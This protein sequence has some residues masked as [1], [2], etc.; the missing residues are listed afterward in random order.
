MDKLVSVP[1]SKKKELKHLDTVYVEWAQGWRAGR[2]KQARKM[3]TSFKGLSVMCLELQGT[4]ESVQDVW[5]LSST[6]Q[7]IQL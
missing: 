3:N 6:S 7:G 4:V 2:L 1:K 5:S